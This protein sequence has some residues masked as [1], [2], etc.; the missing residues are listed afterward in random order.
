MQRRMKN[1]RRAPGRRAT[2]SEKKERTE[3][4]MEENRDD[5]VD[6]WDEPADVADDDESF[7]CC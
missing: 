6:F 2:G 3:D 5:E 7:C 1:S 4:L